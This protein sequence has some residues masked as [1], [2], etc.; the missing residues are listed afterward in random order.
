MI[1]G[2]P[3][4]SILH[5]LGLAVWASCRMRYAW[6]VP[7]D[8]QFTLSH[9]HTRAC[10]HTHTQ[11]F[12][13]NSLLPPCAC[14][15][16]DVCALI[17]AVK[18]SNFESNKIGAASWWQPTA[19]YPRS[20]WQA[21]MLRTHQLFISLSLYYFLSLSISILSMKEEQPKRV[22]N[23]N[24]KKKIT[25]A[26]PCRDWEKENLNWEWCQ[27]VTQRLFRFGCVYCSS[28]L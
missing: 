20:S 21:L 24:R 28:S 14:V 23:L 13:Q 8:K 12:F 4:Q 16:V 1:E 17:I 18:R 26:H 11:S 6:E 5:R 3:A 2:F 19:P 15:S 27:S 9:T 7:T 10:T 25:V 22:E